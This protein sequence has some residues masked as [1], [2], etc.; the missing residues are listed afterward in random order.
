[1]SDVERYVETLAQVNQH[2]YAFLL[3]Y[4]TTW[5]M[6]GLVWRRFGARVGAY[7]ALFQGMVAL[8][9]AL[10]LQ[11]AT[12]QGER[13]IDPVLN[14]LSVYLSTGQ[15]LALPVAIVL[16]MDRR[17]A[18]ATLLLSVVTAVHFAPY[19][20]LYGTPLYVVTAGAITIGVIV[21]LKR[22]GEEAET[23]ATGPPVCLVTG[24]ALLAGALAAL[25]I[26]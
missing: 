15:L 8:P 3:A 2:G 16:I 22:W 9:A 14:E 18:V 20:W 7:T 17:Y 6:T 5:C 24:V 13:P 4:G 12:A 1:M 25:V 19:S 11:A 26:V 23:D 21:V 10:A